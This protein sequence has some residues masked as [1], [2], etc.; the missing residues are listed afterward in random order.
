MTPFEAWS[1]HKLDVTHFRIFGSR[2]W[3]MLPPKL[4]LV[5]FY[6]V[7][8]VNWTRITV[9]T[10][11]DLQSCFWEVVLYYITCSYPMGEL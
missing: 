1:G 4:Y 3:D 6:Q 2:A 8:L 5:V 9:R 10:L 7:I 11:E